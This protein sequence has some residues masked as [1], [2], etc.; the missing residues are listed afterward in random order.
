MRRLRQACSQRLPPLQ[1]HQAAA[2]A[3]MTM[4]HCCHSRCCR[5]CPDELT[6]SPK[7]VATAALRLPSHYQ[8]LTL[9][10]TLR[11]QSRCLAATALFQPT[12]IETAHALRQQYRQRLQN[13]D[14]LMLCQCS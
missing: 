14:V 12:W 3:M 11:V 7:A 9:L 1:Q 8:Q 13:Q 5:C 6:P 4:M 10:R 2:A